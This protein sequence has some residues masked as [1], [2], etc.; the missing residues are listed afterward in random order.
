MISRILENI[1]TRNI[2]KTNNMKKRLLP[3]GFITA[4]FSM[5]LLSFSTLSMAALPG[6]P[7]S[8]KNDVSGWLQSLRVNQHT[9][10][11]NPLDVQ[12]AR[13]QADALRTK[14]SAG[15]NLNWQ[16]MGPDNF[17]GPVWSVIYDNTDP[18]YSRLIAGA[19]SGGIWKSNNNGITWVKMD[20]ADNQILKVSS[21]VQTNTGTVYAA[22]GISTCQ[23]NRFQGSGLYRSENGGMFS[24]VPGTFGNPDWE[25][26]TK[27]A[28]DTRNNHL[29]ASTSTGLLYSEN[30]NDWTK[31]KSGY[32]MDVTVGPDGTILTAIGDSGYI[33]P[34]GDITLFRNIHI[35]KDSIPAGNIGWMVFAIAPSDP[36]M[37]YASLSKLTDGKLKGVYASADKGVSWY[38]IMPNNPTFEPFNG[39]GC[40]AMTLIVHPNDPSQIFLGGLNMWKG[41]RYQPTGYYNWEQVSFGD[42]AIT[43][44]QY[45]P[46]Y[47]HNYF[48]RQNGFA[49]LAMATDGGVTIATL[50]VQEI[51][52]Q[53]INKSLAISQFSSVAYSSQKYFVMGGGVRIGTL[54]LG[55]FYPR[56]T[57]NISDG[58]QM[59]RDN[60]TIQPAN[61]G[62]TGG[63][64]E[65]SSIDPNFAVFSKFKGDSAIRRQDLRDLAYGNA[66]LMKIDTVLSA[67]IPMRIW[68]SFTFNATH[69]SVKIYARVKPIPAD[70]TLWIESANNKFRFPYVTTEPIPIG[71]SLTVADPIANRYF[72]YGSK[73]GYRGIYMTKDMLKMEKD[74]LYFQ[75]FIDESYDDPFTTL[76][77]SADLN[78]LWAGSSAGRLVRISG[79]INAYD[80]ASANIGSSQ[81]VLT[82]TLFTDMPFAGRTITA[83]A[84]NP[85]NSNQIMV[86]LGNYGNTDYVYLTQNGNDPAPVFTSIQDDLPQ[87][88]VYTGI[89]ELHGDN[90]A[91]IGTDVGVFSTNNLSSGSP[92]WLPDMLNIGD[93][94]V[95]EIRQQVIRDYHVENWG[96]IYLSSFGR[97]LWMESS[98]WAPVG[99]DPEP[100]KIT[101]SGSLKLIPNPVKD[102]LKLTFNNIT[103]GNVM[104]YIYDLTGRTVLSA[105]L[106]NHERGTV[107]ATINI[108]NLPAGTY[109]V[110]AGNTYAKMVKI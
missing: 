27:L 100:G 4:L 49:Q 52:Y 13:Q 51:T 3:F 103:A 56:L 80:S 110:K 38:L 84:I 6:N 75:L 97:G 47:H 88:P 26:V 60:N 29:Y 106:G 78:T 32:A 20:V 70:T 99:I 48:F 16:S 43:N 71:D 14:A 45:A 102:N 105:T 40:Y 72:R 62:G 73:D 61:F 85:N 108:N 96:M 92:N 57:N 67:H 50:G 107:T 31:I 95:T 65:W 63:T 77:V 46:L 39:E 66:F 36:N 24:L 19:A 2:I 5:C 104:V 15:L 82:N 81:C 89:I 94:A 101:T 55:Y 21:L 41:V 74:P 28:I 42:Q 37:M 79:L 64:C 83:I 22:T 90:T 86:T 68:E 54:G 1:E 33:A 44:I 93:V 23:N 76:S 18:T 58:Y 91:I 53:T 9:G 87:M 98:Y 69:D 11:V 25:S 109:M 17:T 30:G 35:G 7:D 8:D 12:K 34:G 59:W 10:T